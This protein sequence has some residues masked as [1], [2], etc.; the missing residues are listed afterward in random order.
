MIG[1]ENIAAF[2]WIGLISTLAIGSFYI[3]IKAEMPDEDLEH[4]KE[5]ED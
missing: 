1:I 4:C 5:G 3:L 2:I